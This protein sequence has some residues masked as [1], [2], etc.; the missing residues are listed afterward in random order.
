MSDG[1]LP[2]C[3]HTTGLTLFLFI[4][5]PF[6]LFLSLLWLTTSLFPF[7]VNFARRLFG[8]MDW[9]DLAQDRGGWWALVNA[10]LNLRVP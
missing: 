2:L 1:A 8:C 5:G 4:S 10:I 6:H 3:P 7:T 9:I